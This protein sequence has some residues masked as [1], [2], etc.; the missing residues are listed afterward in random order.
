MHSEVRNATMVGIIL[1][2]LAAVILLSFGVF[3]MVKGTANDGVVENQSVVNNFVNLEVETYN[4]KI[5]T[6]RDV[7]SLLRSNEDLSIFINTPKMMEGKY[8]SLDKD[9]SVQYMNDLP[10]V[11]YGTLLTLSGGAT[12]DELQ[13]IKA[14]DDLTYFDNTLILSNGVVKSAGAYVVDDNGMLIQNREFGACKNDSTV[15]YIDIN[16]KFEANLIKDITDTIIGV[17]FTQMKR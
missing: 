12:I 13:T 10:Y 14:G 8:L 16:S 7:L 4:D 11:N 17:C 1:M 5:V 2:A 3:S 15:E 9:L 6:G